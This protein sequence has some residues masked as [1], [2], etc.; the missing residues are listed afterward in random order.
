MITLP[1]ILNEKWSS[2]GHLPWNVDTL[3]KEKV[4]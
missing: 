2:D 1:S 3:G 4:E